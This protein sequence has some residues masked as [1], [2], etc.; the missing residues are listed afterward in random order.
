MAEVFATVEESLR[1]FERSEILPNAQY[2][3]EFGMNV[4]FLKSKDQFSQEFA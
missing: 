4:N 2:D 3:H 1:S